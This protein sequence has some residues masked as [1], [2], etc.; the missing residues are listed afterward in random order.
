MPPV[1]VPA[2]VFREYDI[3]GV[4]DRDLTDELAHALGRALSTH[5]PGR[6]RV[7]IAVGRDCRLSSERLLAALLAGSSRAAPTSSTSASARRRCST[8][9]SITSRPTA[10]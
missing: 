5:A 7:R 9:R 2:H 3:R 10:A 8:S 4:A 6:A 1:H